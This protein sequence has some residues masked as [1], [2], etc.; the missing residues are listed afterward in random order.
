MFLIWLVCLC[1]HSPEAAPPAMNEGRPFRLRMLV[2]DRAPWAAIYEKLDS[3]QSP[4]ERRRTIL[5][6]TRAA[7]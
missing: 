3:R 5:R 7:H 6:L 2:R 1:K 4:V